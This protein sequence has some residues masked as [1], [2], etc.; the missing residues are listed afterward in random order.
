MCRAPLKTS[1]SRQFQCVLTCVYPC[2]SHAVGDATQVIAWYS[3]LVRGVVALALAFSLPRNSKHTI[4][5][6]L[7]RG[8]FVVLLVCIFSSVVL[9]PSAKWVLKAT[10]YRYYFCSPVDSEDAPDEV[11]SPWG[12]R[13][14]GLLTF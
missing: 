1:S 5:I 12:Y 4:E 13:R 6:E 11:I 8:M 2:V 9:G 14:T 7:Q 3:G 10:Q